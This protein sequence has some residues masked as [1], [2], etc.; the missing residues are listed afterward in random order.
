MEKSRKR[1]YRRKVK[2]SKCG[3]ELDG[4]Y[5]TEHLKRVHEYDQQVEFHP[6]IDPKQR[7]LSFGVATSTK[8]SEA[9]PTEATTS[10]EDVSITTGDDNNEEI[11]DQ[12]PAEPDIEVLVTKAKDTGA[13]P[14]TD[15]EGPEEKLVVAETLAETDIQ[16]GPNQPL[17]DT[18][19]RK[20]LGKESG[21]RDFNPNL[22]KKYPWT[23]FDTATKSIICFP[24]EKFLFDYSFT[25]SNWKKPERLAKHA[26]SRNH[27]MAMS[28]WIQSKVHHNRESSV[29][30]QLDTAH[31]DMVEKNRAY[32]KVII[33]SILYTA[34]QNI[35]QRG[36]IEDRSNIGKQSDVNRGNLIELLHLRC[37]DIPWLAAKLNSQ[38]EAHHQWLSPDVQNEIL[39]ITSDLVLNHISQV[40]KEAGRFS[41]IAD[42]TSDVG[43]KEQIAIC[44]RY[45]YK[46]QPT[47]TFLGFYEAQSTT[48][49]A[50]FNMILEVLKSMKL[51]I[52]D[53]VGQCYDGASNITK[54]ALHGI[55]GSLLGWTSNW[56]K[57]RKQRVVLNGKTS[58]WKSVASGVPQGSVLGPLLFIVY[59]N[60][61]DHGLKSTVSKFADDTKLC[62]VANDHSNQLDIQEDLDKLQQWSEKWLMKFNTSKCK[63]MHLGKNNSKYDYKLFGN[64][65]TKVDSEKDLG[66]IISNDLKSSKQCIS[67]SEKANKILG[68]IARSFDFKSP[69]LINKLYKSLVRPHLEYAVSVWSPNLI[70]DIDRLEKV[71]RRATK[72]IP[73]IKNKSY[74]NR[75]K[76]MN[77][78]SLKKRRLRG[79]LIQVF[80][81][82]KGIDNIKSDQIFTLNEN[83]TRNNGLKLSGNRF[84]LE[85][86]RN[87]FANRV[88]N[89]WNKLPA[90]VVQC[91]SVRSFKNHLDKY[92]SKML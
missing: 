3:K 57:G 75:L 10:I 78:F 33:E 50:L 56:L 76:H 86:G 23:S 44:L 58:G 62:G 80:K 40:V 18:Y 36:H 71:Q 5:K 81:I 25:F 39:N 77:L 82:L 14:A 21:T 32:L 66:V 30:T 85:V 35:P 72:L 65:L 13:P 42:E 52:E 68:L 55:S 49:E 46:A 79:D 29:L 48:G 41:L 20:Q 7:K 24:C 43:N 19:N 63:V 11:Q 8:L 83:Q 61:I 15:S 1:L 60:D 27:S 38:L 54:L 4:D 87:N 67:A 73:N 90:P 28:K 59:I 17:L 89:E 70:K 91:S 64:S 74:E 47:E 26:S 6:V 69:S 2:C 31:R 12:V 88:V 16:T 34:Q 84:N 9:M 53:A 92:L 51:R 22:F 37:K 45:I